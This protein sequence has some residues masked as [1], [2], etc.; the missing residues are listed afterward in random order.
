VQRFEA[1]VKPLGEARPGWK[2]LRVLA[3]Q[4]RASGFDYNVLDDVRAELGFPSWFKPSTF[5]PGSPAPPARTPLADG[6]LFRIAEV[7]LYVIDPLVRRA[8]V[9][10]A[11]ADNPPPRVRLNAADARRLGLENGAPVVVQTVAG[12]ARLSVHVDARV[13]EG[14]VSIAAGYPETAALGAHGPASV[15]R[16]R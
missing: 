10:A 3:N 2:I 12:E 16:S 11:T 14:A 1:A 9:L 13:P 5:E 6:Q 4:L 8:P 15:V 7:P